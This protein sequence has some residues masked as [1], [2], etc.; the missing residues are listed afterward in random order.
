MLRVAFAGAVIGLLSCNPS[1]PSDPTGPE[2]LVRSFVQAQQALMQQN[3]GEPEVQ[4]VLHFLSDSFVYEHP[5][6]RATISGRNEFGEGLRRFLGG[7]Q[8]A[9]IRIVSTLVDGGVVVTEQDI[10][11]DVK[12]EGEWRPDGRTQVT[13]FD[14][15]NGR[16]A[17]IVDFWQPKSGGS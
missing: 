13:V 2:T 12:R 1:R 5:R 7:T 15:E 9:Q 17:R 11:F 8:K 16:I 14:V 10:S 4:A 3:A 6:A